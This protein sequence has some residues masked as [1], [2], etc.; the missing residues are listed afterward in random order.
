MRLILPT[1]VLLLTSVSPPAV[2]AQTSADT[3]APAPI[4]LPMLDVEG[5]SFRERADGPVEGYRATRSGSATRTDTPIQEIPQSISVVPRQ[6]LEDLGSTRVESALDYAGGIARQ[7]NFG[8][9]TLFEYGVRG[10]TTSEFYRNGFPVNRGYQAAPDAATIERVEVL[11]GPAALLYGRGDPGGT[12]NIVTRQPQDVAQYGLTGQTDSRGSLRGTVDAG[13]P[14]DA[15]GRFLYRLGAGREN[16]RS[17]REF[18]VTDRQFLAPNLTWRLSPE[19]TITL[20]AEFLRNDQTFDRGVVAVRNRL[21]AIPRSRFLGE[22]NGGRIRNE[23]AMTQLRLDHR[24]SN[25]WTLRVG[26]QYLGGSLTGNA[27]ENSSL[28]GDGRSLVRERRFRDFEWTD[29]DLQASL[30]G[31]FATG[32]LRHTLSLGVEYENY[33]NREILLRSNPA[34]APYVI[35]IYNP[36]YVRTAPALTRRSDTLE[37]TTTYAAFVQDQIAIT[38]R[39]KA[40]A[41]VRLERFEQDFVQRATATASPQ[42]HTAVT[43]R[44]GLI[45]D[46]TDQ[47]AVYASAARSFKP[48]RGGDAAGRSFA[49]EDGV[50]YEAGVKLDLLQSR[51]G[52]TAALFQIEKENV[53]TPDAANAGFSVAAGEARSRGFDVSV[54]GNLTPAWRIIG[55][56]A[57]IDAEITRDNLLRPGTPLVNIPRHSG[58]LLNVYEIQDG[59]LAGLGL[60]GGVTFVGARAGDASGSGFRLPSYTTVDAL[61][62]WRINENLRVNLNVTNLFDKDY[63]DR[64]VS[65]VW[66]SPGA[67]RTALASVS[68]RF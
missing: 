44:L 36:A 18:V 49:P 8:G 10:F 43:P 55:G 60:G 17:F 41:G 12:F 13:G 47:V 39:L 11:R 31:Q 26:G 21:G 48:N 38:P 7:N 32:P 27:I 54:S 56:Y 14:L 1:A 37:R 33:R 53:L 57:Y 42:D 45:Y 2:L 30:V 67:P 19:T 66:V 23:N 40:V 64:S 28:L 25:D 61:A 58:S 29:F 3:E 34:S 16:T 35:D 9:Q 20:E 59:R 50:A 15:A 65:S 68:M 62:Y 63:Y 51:L 6:V 24:L 46:L 22:P 5:R 52:I 4:E